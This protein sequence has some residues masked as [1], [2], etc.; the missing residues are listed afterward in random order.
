[1]ACWL[2]RAD[3]RCACG[4]AIRASRPR[5]A[6][7]KRS[8]VMPWLLDTNAWIFYQKNPAHR[9]HDELAKREPS[10]IFTCS[11]VRAELLHG[12]M[13]YGIP[14]RRRAIILKTL[15]PYRSLPFDDAAAE[16]YAQ[17]RHISNWPAKSS[18]QTTSS[19]PPSA[20]RTTS[21]SSPA[22]LLSF[23]EWQGCA[24]RIGTRVAN[25]EN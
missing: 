11:I 13:K 15:A 7:A 9:I 20:S 21:P 8:L 24:W 17:L 5:N 16:H 1:M 18:G 23:H 22:T 4:R 19:S 14:E 6:G 10:D 12:A 2:F 25:H 3:S